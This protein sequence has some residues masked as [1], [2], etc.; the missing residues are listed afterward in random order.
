MPR[1]AAIFAALTSE[2]LRDFLPEPLL[3]R[4]RGLTDHFT[5]WDP[6]GRSAAEFAAALTAANPEVLL[7]CWKTPPLPEPLPPRLRYVCYLCGSVRRLVTRQQIER[8]LLVSNWGGSISRV[9]AEWALFHILSCLRRATH[10]TIAM[11]HEGA[12]KDG[13]TATASLFGRR[14]GLHGFGQIA[15][16]LVQLLRPFQVTISSFA[17]DI[18][19]A[20][21]A[22]HGIHR[23]ATLEALFAE[24]DIIVELAPLNEATR[25]V[26]GESLLRLIRPGG[27]FVNVG[28]GAVV[29]EAAL[30]RVAQAGQ[31]LVGL[32]VYGVEPLPVDSPFRGLRNVSL[33]PHIAGPTTDR[34]CDAGAFAVANLEAYAAGRPLQAVITPGIYDTST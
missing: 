34:R 14:V 32:D 23:A 16:E 15:R 13:G 19:P 29:D 24:N 28:R 20:V 8:G 25:G 26:V 27:V 5:T 7:A 2:E 4:A 30:L 22:A 9:V 3:G 10:W 17:P 6:A 21:E 11:H 18:T 12:W 1:P 33:T 31:I